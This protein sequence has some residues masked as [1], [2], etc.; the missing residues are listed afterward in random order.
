[1]DVKFM[2]AKNADKIMEKKFILVHYF[3]K[4]VKSCKY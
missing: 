3:I 4:T 2:W 1:M